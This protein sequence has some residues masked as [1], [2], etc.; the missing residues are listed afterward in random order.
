LSFLASPN[1]M[2]SF[3]CGDGIMMMVSNTCELEDSSSTDE[4]RRME[5]GVPCTGPFD[6]V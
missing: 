6:R 3:T 2:D 5:A 4:R 1:T